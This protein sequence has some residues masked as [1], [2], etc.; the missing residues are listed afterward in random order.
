MDFQEELELQDVID[1]SLMWKTE[2]YMRTLEGVLKFYMAHVLSASQIHRT[3][4]S[5]FSL[6]RLH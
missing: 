2:V 3:K 5:V 1:S 6:S 4:Y